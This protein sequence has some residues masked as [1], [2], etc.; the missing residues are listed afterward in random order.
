MWIHPKSKPRVA[1]ILIGT[2]KPSITIFAH[3]SM[4]FSW[5]YFRGE[6]PELDDPADEVGAAFEAES[7]GVVVQP[8]EESRGRIE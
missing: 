3:E 7:F 1:R 2:E 6:K 5:R 4:Y 8:F